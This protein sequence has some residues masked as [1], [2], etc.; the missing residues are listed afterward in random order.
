[1]PPVSRTLG[2]GVRGQWGVGGKQQ[3]G[4]ARAEGGHCVAGEGWPL[5]WV[6]GPSG[7]AVP[8]VSRTVGWGVRWWRGVG[9]KQQKGQA[10]AGGGEGVVGEGWPVQWAVGPS[11][12]AMP[13]VSRTLGWD[14]R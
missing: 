12:G 13:P 8:S 3:K 1:M 6:D 10:L 11:G 2:W 9:G 5:Q 7:G 4:Q 14:V